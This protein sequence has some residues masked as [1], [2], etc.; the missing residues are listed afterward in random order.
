MITTHDGGH[1]WVKTTI[2]DFP[3]AASMNAYS[4]DCPSLGHCMAIEYGTG[5]AAIVVS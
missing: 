3:A 4:L 1:S 5:P 2:S